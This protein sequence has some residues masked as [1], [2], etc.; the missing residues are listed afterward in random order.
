MKDKER[1]KEQL[2][3]ELQILRKQAVE[4]KR[5]GA[6]HKRME[7]ALNDALKESRRRYAEILALLEGTR[8]VS[9]YRE[10]K[11]TAR[12]LFDSCK[13][14]IGAT[15]GY[16][17]LL[18]K[19]GTENEV[20]FLDSGGGGCTVD[21]ALPMPI[22]GLRGEAYHTGSAVYHNDFSK[23]EWAKY[24]P[25]GHASL[26]N[27]LFA[28]L[29]IEG[30][31][32][33]LLGLANKPGGFNK[34]D[35]R[36]ASAFGELTAIALYNSRVLE[37]LEESRERFRSVVETANDAIISADSCG[38]TIFWN[39]AAKAIFGYSEDEV[40]G[41]P[42]TVLMPE[43]YRDAHRKALER[44][45]LTGEAHIVGK[46]V[47]LH[48]LRKDGSEFPLELSISVWTTREGK[49]YSAII[50]DITDRRQAEEEIK[51]LN[52]ELRRRAAEL[53]VINKELETFAYSVSHDLRA[54]LRSIDGFTQALLEDFSDKINGQGRDYFRRVRAATHRMAQMIDDMLRLSRATRTG[55]QRQVVD[56]GAMA[57][58]IADELQK[59]QPGRL[60]EFVI[61]SGMMVK[62]DNRLLRAVLEN[63]LDNA[64]KFTS[65][66]THA[67][68]EFG[69]AE[70]EG[71]P[72][73]FVRD[74]GVGFDMAYAGKLF[75]PFQR[76]HSSDEFPGTGIGLATVQRIINRHGGCVWAEG[77]VQKGAT[78]YFS[79]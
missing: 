66:H 25:E 50:R 27:V 1:T 26:D 68:I 21:P 51:K 39:N 23:S 55:M 63:L 70:K 16:V 79:L 20:L 7:K 44:F 67:R 13:N 29:V 77:E 30:K 52:D 3:E 71:K 56:L 36:V 11:D 61:G 19:D 47:Q 5:A 12:T 42:L 74:D 6:G 24:M 37:S 8:A 78:F 62:G 33:G 31:A 43:R 48:G 40:L 41:K 73:Y 38:K 15:A 49:F 69:V 76:L 28:P 9:K 59:A 57:R 34:D 64:W 14:L 2:I 58:S 45:G 53:E 10:F 65:K 35:V 22:R 18:T 60:V 75:S 46:T 4:L 54:P 72:V 17:A 32:V